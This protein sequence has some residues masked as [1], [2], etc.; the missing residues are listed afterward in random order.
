MKFMYSFDEKFDKSYVSI[1]LN[2]MV[3]CQKHVNEK[4][5]NMLL[6]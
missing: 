4:I 6:S 2:N 5:P 1:L 3:I